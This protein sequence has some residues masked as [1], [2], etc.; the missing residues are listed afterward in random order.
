[1]PFCA[2]VAELVDAADSKSAA[3]KSVWVRFPPPAPYPLLSNLIKL[4][5]VSFIAA[6]FPVI[7][8]NYCCFQYLSISFKL[9]GATSLKKL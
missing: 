5:F 1:M 2:E 4:H 6:P 3:L 9:I 8:N 7:S